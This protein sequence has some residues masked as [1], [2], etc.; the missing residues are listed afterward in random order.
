MV[1]S[2]LKTGMYAVTKNG[3][4]WLIVIIEG[5]PYLSYPSGWMNIV[6]FPRVCSYD[7][8]Y[9]IVEVYYGISPN[10]KSN[11]AYL[12]Q[13]D[14]YSRYIKTNNIEHSLEKIW[15]SESAKETIKIGEITYDKSEFEQ[16][17]KD[18]KPINK[19]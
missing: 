14:I 19:L 13:Y 9:D 12:L 3:Q 15:T 2:D 17:V 5:E 1:K 10:K 6:N 18:L 4:I 8:S 16:A 7:D 11:K